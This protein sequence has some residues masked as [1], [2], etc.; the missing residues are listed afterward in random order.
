MARYSRANPDSQNFGLRS[1]D[2]GKAGENALREDMQSFRSIETMSDRFS[3]FAAFVRE[4]FN[5]K[6]MRQLEREHIQLYADS[7]REKCENSELAPATAQNYLSAVN[8]VLEIA[9]GDK[10]LHVA[11]VH[12]AGI[13]QRTGIATENHRPDPAMLNAAI[14][15]LPER[16]SAQIELQRNLGLRFEESCKINAVRTLSQAEKTGTVT[17][18]DG[19]K[20]GRSRTLS[21]VSTEQIK[22]LK[23]AAS[24]QGNDRSLIPKAQTYKDFRNEA[25]QAIRHAGLSGF[26]G[27]RHEYAQ[28]R[29]Q[30]LTG[31]LCPVVSGVQHGTQHHQHLATQLNITV[32][33]AKSADQAARLQIAR[34]LGHNRIDVTNSYLG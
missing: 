14:Q 10:T 3:L 1:R 34:E 8:R 2:M 24:I 30:Q 20:G 6:D 25:Y 26:H 31:Q 32:A 11:P 12:D 16:I 21:I 29:Y 4:E 23:Q 15:Q 18:S 9:R 7:L 33:A 27:N 28:N 19:T 17:I 13:P 5:I 22:S